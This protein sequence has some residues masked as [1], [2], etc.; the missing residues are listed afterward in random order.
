M[1]FDGIITRSIISELNTSILGGKINKVFQPTNNDIIL[2]IYS[3]GRHYALQICID[4]N[5]CRINLTTNSKPNPFHAPNFC[6]FLRKHTIGTK[7][8]SIS[9]YDLERVITIEL[10][11]Y[12]EL[13]DLITKKLVIELMGKHSNIILLNSTNIILD[14]LRH[15]D[16]SNNCYRDILPAHEYCSP[17]TDKH[18]IL[19]IEFDCFYEL[20][21]SETIH[22][23]SKRLSQSFIGISRSFILHTLTI[24]NISTIDKESL[25]TLFSYIK[26]IISLTETD[27]VSCELFLDP[28]Q[29]QDYCLIKSNK[30]TNLSI[31]FFIDDFYHQKENSEI[32]LNYRNNIL[33]ILS[34]SLKKYN[35]RL[36]NI[37]HKLE[38]C[39]NMETYQLYGELITS[40][41]YRIPN[42]N[43]DYIEL[44]NYYDYNNLIQIPLDNTISPA[45]NAKKYFKKY[46]K[47]KNTL[48][49]ATE[50]KKE[51]KKELDYIESILYELEASKT[52]QDVDAIYIEI[53]DNLL[54]ISSKANSKTNTK[55]K[56]KNTLNSIS[57]IEYEINGYKVL[58]GKNNKQ[59]DYLT[60][61]IAEKTDLWFHTKDIHGSHVI[62]KTNRNK[63]IDQD[64]LQKCAKLATEHS[65]AKNSS[66]TPVDYTFVQYVKKPSGAKPGKVI[67]TNQKTIY[68]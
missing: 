21:K 43:T 8:K 51:T 65:K 24:L 14:S 36:E 22:S 50:Q 53:Q 2:G 49:I 61:K 10:E 63:T 31:N 27:K 33:K 35:K 56:E 37:N 11:G 41:L 1:A 46:H 23:I 42:K 60:F 3:N 4:S 48:S 67:Y 20:L 7:I 66:N 45:N 29:K 44:E 52:I 16:K 13:D 54:K 12:N 9:N 58:V 39:S 6:M 64:T 55:K 28:N 19:S 68:V 59:N 5:N 25:F 26:E 32:F 17:K 30:E 15:L 38:E 62:L 40:N 57:P 47:L 18:S 34:N